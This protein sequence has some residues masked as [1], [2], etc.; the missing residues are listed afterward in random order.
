[1]G[2]YGTSWGFA[3]EEYD[4]PLLTFR[5]AA[6][7]IRRIMMCRMINSFL[8]VIVTLPVV[9]S[10]S[11]AENIDFDHYGYER[12]ERDWNDP[13]AKCADP[14][15]LLNGYYSLAFV[16]RFFTPRVPDA[17][18]VHLSTFMSSEGFKF[19]FLPLPLGDKMANDLFDY[20]YPRI[21]KKE[22]ME[23]HPS[24][25]IFPAAKANG[26]ALEITFPNGVTYSLKKMGHFYLGGNFYKGKAFKL[27]IFFKRVSVKNN[28]QFL[29]N[30][31]NEK[32]A[33]VNLTKADWFAGQKLVF[34]ML[35]CFS[36]SYRMGNDSGYRGSRRFAEWN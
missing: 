36:D 26:G 29:D 21:P 1:M 11:F 14:T 24:F 33:R 3:K 31:F 10:I 4:F 7:L 2:G 30:I 16:G 28:A 34:K 12:L 27:G 22:E 20:S 19:G 23:N 15:D 18:K 13:S 9:C 5:E 35:R 25:K 6:V 8:W 32:F 17:E